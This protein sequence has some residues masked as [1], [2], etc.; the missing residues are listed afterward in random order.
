MLWMIGGKN[1]RAGIWPSGRSNGGLAGRGF[2]SLTAY[3]AKSCRAKVKA[4]DR[5]R[6]LFFLAVCLMEELDSPMTQKDTDKPINEHTAASENEGSSAGP[7]SGFRVLDLSSVVSGPMAAVVLADQGADVIKVEPPGWGDGIRGLGASRN[8]LSAIYAMINRNKRSVAINLKHEAGQDLIRQLVKDADVLL[9]N[10]RPGKMQNLGLDY[11]ALKAINPELI[12]ASINGMGEVGP[13]A[14]QK[15]YD[16]VIQALSGVLDVQ[17]GGPNSADGQSLQMVRTILYDKITALTAAQG[18][19]AA[20]LARERG[21]GGQHVQL[22]MLDT[23]IYFNW[24]DLMWNYS[25]LGQGAQLA[26]DLADVCEVS[27]TADGAIVS[28]YL[29]VDCSQYET[30]QL[31]DLLTQN[32]IPVGKVNRRADLINDPQ[33]AATGILHS[34]DH[35]RGGEMMQP[36]AAVRFSATQQTHHVPS[37]DLGQ[38]TVEILSDLGLTFAQMQDLARQGVIA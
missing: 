16:Y 9:Q 29:G 3:Y 14:G 5:R 38:H 2:S 15:T 37:A 34:L 10:Y 1:A 35:P 23:A 18:I 19:T 27:E 22:S 13:Y 6:S 31:V 4:W 24:P 21:A 11:H 32:E 28:S 25:F 8:G 30:D 20:L 12:Y 36:R 17:G 26:G 7:L 33:V